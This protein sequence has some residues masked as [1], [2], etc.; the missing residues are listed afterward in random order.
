MQ[1]REQYHSKYTL[2]AEAQKR[3]L[4]ERECLIELFEEHGK[5]ADVAKYLNINTSNILRHIRKHGLKRH[6]VLIEAG[7][8]SK[9]TRKYALMEEAIKRGLTERECLIKLFE[10]H[11]KQEAVAEY[12]GVHTT[13]IWQQTRK[14]GLKRHTILVE[15][16]E[17]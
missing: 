13:A 8:P 12:L 14:H 15:N 16:N 3:G 2:R 4:T 10:E 9:K 6:T 7:T 1:P 5:Q 17:N 11:G